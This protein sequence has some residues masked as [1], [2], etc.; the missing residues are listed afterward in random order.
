M[1]S[2]DTKH[3]QIKILPVSGADRRR[4]VFSGSYRSGYP[5]LSVYPLRQ[6]RLFCIVGEVESLSPMP[7]KGRRP[8][9]NATTVSLLGGPDRVAETTLIIP[10]KKYWRAG[11]G[12]RHFAHHTLAVLWLRVAVWS[13]TA[14]TVDIGLA[15]E[16]RAAIIM[17]TGTL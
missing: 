11:A 14:S 9:E 5:R 3:G 8:T 7:P 13:A 17:N 12:V 10:K 4:S 16:N 1:P 6:R 2:D 15:K